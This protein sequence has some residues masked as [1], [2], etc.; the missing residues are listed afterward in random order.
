MDSIITAVMANIGYFMLGIG[1][2]GLL[3]AMNRD[4]EEEGYDAYYD[5]PYFSDYTSDL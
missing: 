5:D 4:I 3:W 1:F 2:G